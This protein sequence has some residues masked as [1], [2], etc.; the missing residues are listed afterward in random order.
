[1]STRKT[2]TYICDG[3]GK[4]IE[5]PCIRVETRQALYENSSTIILHSQDKNNKVWSFEAGDFC[6][7][8]CLLIWIKEKLTNLK[9]LL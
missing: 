2:T 9:D 1:M 6:S 5:R 3:C 7:T 4:D 8:T